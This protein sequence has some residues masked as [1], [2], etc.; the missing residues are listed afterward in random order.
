VG[1]HL[2]RSA[3]NEIAVN[4]ARLGE[5]SPASVGDNV[6]P[7]YR[8]S[9]W[10]PDVRAATLTPG[11][12]DAVAPGPK[13]LQQPFHDEA[14]DSSILVPQAGRVHPAARIGSTRSNLINKG[15][16]PRASQNLGPMIGERAL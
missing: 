4:S 2:R 5:A 7:P 8:G 9:R 6:S 15:R 11:K 3:V 16:R 1:A 14:K 12:R 10:A 13:G